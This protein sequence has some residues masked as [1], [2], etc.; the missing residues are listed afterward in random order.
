MPAEPIAMPLEDAVSGAPAAG[1]SS[2]GGAALA[3]NNRM[4]AEQMRLGESCKWRARGRPLVYE[5]ERRSR[6]NIERPL[7]RRVRR[8]LRWRAR[9]KPGV[10]EGIAARGLVNS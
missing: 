8:V 4:P 5:A 3:G 10:T 7:S 2:Q 9:N 1:R 6:A